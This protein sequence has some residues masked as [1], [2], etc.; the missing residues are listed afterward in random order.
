LSS[1]APS[2]SESNHSN[3]DE[4]EEE[5]EKDDATDDGRK[6]SDEDKKDSEEDEMDVPGTLLPSGEHLSKLICSEPLQHTLLILTKVLVSFKHPFEGQHPA[7]QVYVNN[8]KIMCSTSPGGTIKN[9]AMLTDVIHKAIENNSPI[10][11]S[12]V[13]SSSY[14]DAQYHMYRSR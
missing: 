5:E 10:K 2:S 6:D 4:E 9:E 11:G 7:E 8:V 1:I 12:S 13:S 3:R 14:G